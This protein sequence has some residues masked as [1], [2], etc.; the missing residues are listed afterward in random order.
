MV[1]CFF[2]ANF[3]TFY[4]SSYELKYLVVFKEI[5]LNTNSPTRENIQSHLPYN[6]ISLLKHFDILLIMIDEFDNM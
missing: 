3:I 6:P 5:S 4:L 1:K 2:V